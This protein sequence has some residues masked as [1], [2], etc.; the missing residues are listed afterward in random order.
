MVPV[1]TKKS[2]D[3]AWHPA[4]P[5]QHRHGYAAGL[6]RDLPTSTPSQLR[7]QPTHTGWPCTAPRPISTRFEPVPRLRSVTT[8][9]S[10]YTF[11]SRSPDP[12]R[13]AVPDRPSFVSAASRP[14]RRLPDQTALSSHPLLRQPG[15]EVSHLPRFPA[16]QRTSASWRTSTDRAAPCPSSRPAPGCRRPAWPA[17]G[18]PRTHATRPARTD[19]ESTRQP[20]PRRPV[21]ELFLPGARVAD[22]HRA[23]VGEPAVVVLVHC[24]A[25][26]PEP[27]GQLVS[28]SQPRRAVVTH[29]SGPRRH[30][31]GGL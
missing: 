4:F 9:S 25:P 15:E 6:H 31:H 12:A 22:L 17:R 14:Y 28:L 16:P 10:S 1:F 18:P 27:P 23:V 21:T 24:A 7:S 8:G 20:R 5:R 2:I 19:L 26:V 13:L 3:R 29:T 30:A 11:R